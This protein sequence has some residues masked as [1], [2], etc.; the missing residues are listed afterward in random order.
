MKKNNYKLTDIAVPVAKYYEQRRKGKFNKAVL[1][2]KLGKYQLLSARKVNPKSPCVCAGVYKDDKG[3][4]MFVKYTHGSKKSYTY[5]TFAN[6]ARTYQVL[7]SIEKTLSKK[8]KDSKINA[9]FPE[10]IEFIEKEDFSYMV[11][12]YIN[13]QTIEN[14]TSQQK[15]KALDEA[16]KYLSFLSKHTHKRYRKLLSKRSNRDLLAMYP[17]LLAVA[18]FNYPGKYKELLK[19]A[20][21]VLKNSRDLLGRKELALV[22]RDLHDNN[23]MVSGKEIY[24]IDPQFFVLADPLLEYAYLTK[25]NIED[26]AV[27]EFLS[28]RTKNEISRAFMVMVATHSL[29]ERNRSKKSLKRIGKFLNHSLS[30]SLA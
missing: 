24:I 28:G 16:E 22:H 4:K 19:G 17:A 12:E 9:Q 3:K 6:E 26:R 18:L 2:K 1:P 5:H 10:L 25:F 29:I 8:I 21:T 14:L 13:G 27:Q 11:L 7:N 30:I 15:I 23:F 20:L